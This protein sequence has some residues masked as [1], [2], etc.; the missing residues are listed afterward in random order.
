MMGLLIRKG[1][2]GHRETQKED[3]HVKRQVETG[4]LVPQPGNTRDCQQLPETGGG[5]EGFS[6]RFLRG[7]MA[8]P[9]PQFQ[10]S[11]LQK[12]E[13]INSHCFKPLSLW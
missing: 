10:S 1:T 9:T 13:R 5:K 12:H 2:L 6:P 3:G 11:S 4:V 8:L 7:S